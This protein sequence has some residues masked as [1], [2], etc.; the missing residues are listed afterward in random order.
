MGQIFLKENCPFLVRVSNNM[1][2]LASTYL[3]QPTRINVAGQAYI[4][5]TPLTLDTT[6]TGFGGLD[7]G[8]M[9]ADTLYYIYLCTDG[10]GNLGLVTSLSSPVTGPSGFANRYRF[11]GKFRTRFGSTAIAVVATSKEINPSL[12]AQQLWNSYTPVG[13]WVTNTSYTGTKRYVNENVE[14]VIRLGLTGA[15]TATALTIELPDSFTFR[16]FG[17]AVPFLARL[18]DTSTPANRQLGH[19]IVSTGTNNFLVR[20]LAVG[21]VDVTATTPFTWANTDFI[22]LSMSVPVAELTDLYT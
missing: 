1:I 3:G 2:T 4:V 15:P 14:M 7:T 10:S 22:Q 13:S 12:D 8:V 17:G 16:G 18:V 20:T 21:D 6:V 5:A 11:L 9:T 19:V